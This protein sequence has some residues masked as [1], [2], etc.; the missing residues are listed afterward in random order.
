MGANATREGGTCAVWLPA[1]CRREMPSAAQQAELPP[2]GR[3][4]YAHFFGTGAEMALQRRNTNLTLRS[5]HRRSETGR[6]MVGRVRSGRA[7]S[8]D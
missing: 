2:R 6:G 7:E 8:M 1:G 5:W 4:A 3:R